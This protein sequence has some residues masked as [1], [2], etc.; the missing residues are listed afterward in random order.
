MIPKGLALL[1]ATE[2]GPEWL[3]RLPTLV[4]ACI[5]QWSLEVGDPFPGGYAS[6]ALPA[7]QA[8]GTRVVLKVCFPAPRER[9]RGRRPLPVGRRRRGSAAR[10]RP[11]AWRLAPRA[12][13]AGDAP[14]RA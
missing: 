5:E 7:T 8:D 13:R 11:R 9:A 10:T 3:E 1:R 6:L 14:L 2:G 12:L 4:E